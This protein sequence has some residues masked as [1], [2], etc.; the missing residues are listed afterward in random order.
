LAELVAAKHAAA[1]E[2][3][4]RSE[5]LAGV[6]VGTRLREGRP[7]GEACVRLYVE[8]K[9]PAAE[10]A[11][12]AILPSSIGGFRT[13]VVETGRFTAGPG[14][15]ARTRQRVRPVRPGCSVGHGQP[16]AGTIGAVVRDRAGE[17]HI[18]SCNHVLADENALA[19]GAAIYQPA[20][21]D[22][23]RLDRDQVASLSRFVPLG[24][25]NRVDVALARA[26]N[27]Y[28]LDGSILPHARLMRLPPGRA[29]AGQRVHKSGRSTGHTRGLVIDASVDLKIFY[30]SGVLRFEEQLL[31]E[32]AG[33][34]LPGDS[35]ALIVEEE[36]HRPVGL[37][38]AGSPSHT[39][40]N[41]IGEVLAALDVELV[42]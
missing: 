34:S 9:R 3:L 5:A 37:L 32:G 25:H 27:R 39:V 11:T 17:L 8:H 20:L 31:I 10:L 29:R 33:F 24:P 22:E 42:P 36:S 35:G 26:D 1:A 14:R 6:G 4:A 41:P 7:T 13:D 28:N 19:Q 30:R 15:A 23:G 40:A 16:M 18:L 12:G 2:L 21:L 38:F